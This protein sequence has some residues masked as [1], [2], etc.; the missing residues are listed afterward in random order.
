MGVLI[1]ED[2]GI[3]NSIKPATRSAP[4]PLTAA[5]AATGIRRMHLLDTMDV[6]TGK[7]VLGN[8]HLFLQENGNIWRALGQASSWV[9]AERNYNALEEMESKLH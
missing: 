3:Q 7:T 8:D 2:N 9:Q 6:I 4:W 5:K 1:I